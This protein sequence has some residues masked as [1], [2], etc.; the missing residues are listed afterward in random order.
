MKLILDV[1]DVPL[2]NINNL[3]IERELDLI[4]EKDKCYINLLEVKNGKNIK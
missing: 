4:I 1:T 2:V 3:C